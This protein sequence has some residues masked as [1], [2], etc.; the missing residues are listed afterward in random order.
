MAEAL[1]NWLAEPA[2]L[3][4]LGTV[5]VFAV[6]YLISR[7]SPRKPPIPL[8]RQSIEVG[9]ITEEQE[10]FSLFQLFNLQK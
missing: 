1:V 4:G 5:A 7:P 9:R 3:I 2:T 6:Y 10:P 8:D